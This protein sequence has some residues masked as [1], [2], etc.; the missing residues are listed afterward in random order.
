MV[1][2]DSVFISYRRSDARA[3]A[4]GLAHELSSRLGADH[5]FLDTESIEGGQD[6]P[7]RIQEAL[8]RAR[9]VLVVIGSNWLRAADEWGVRRIDNEEDFVRREVIYALET[10]GVTTIPILLDGGKMPPK[11]K[12]P[13]VIS[14]L[15]E[16]QLMPLDHTQFQGHVNQ[17]AEHIRKLGVEAIGISSSPNTSARFDPEPRDLA[18]YR[19]ALE[20][21]HSAMELVGFQTR[22]RVPIDIEELHVPLRAL[23]D[24]RAHGEAVFS[25]AEDAEKSLQKAEGA[26][27]IQ[28]S[29]AFREA[30]RLRRRGLVILGDPG[31]GK[32][33]QLKCLL[34]WLL[35]RG[36]SDLG[37]GNG[38]P[39]VPV[40]LRL[41][42]LRDI[43]ADLEVFIEQQ[44]A[45]V[46][47]DLTP[48]FGKALL[49]RGR[50]LLLFDGLDEVADPTS[51]AVVARWIEKVSRQRPTSMPVVT[52]RFAGYGGDARL[53]EMFLELH[54]RPLTSEQAE[55]FIS[56]WYDVVEAGLAA[57]PAKSSNQAHQ[58]ATALIER[59]RE[60]DF[61]TAR[62]AQMTR[63][64]LLLANLCLVHRDSG[65]L[66][67]GRARLYTE[68]VDVLLERWREGKDL[69][70][71]VPSEVGRRALQPAAL[72]LHGQKG[73]DELRRTRATA[74][75]LAP[76]IES[77]LKSARWQGGNAADFLRAV[78]DES[79]LLTGWG[80]EHFG[81][82]HLGFQEYL[83]ASEVRRR[84]AE[85]DA[86]P[87]KDLAAQYGVSWW[88]EVILL[89]LS[90]SNPSMF[91]RFMREVVKQRSFGETFEPMGLI[92][93]DAVEVSDAP[94]I[95]LLEEVPEN[96]E[97][98]WQRQLNALRALEAIGART[99]IDSLRER[100]SQHPLAAI[101]AR[102][103]PPKEQPLGSAAAKLVHEVTGIE[104]V[105]IPG[106]TFFMGSNGKHD[107]DESP[108]HRV[109][110]SG[111][112]IS[113]YP[114]T[115]EQYARFLQANL[116]VKE[117]RY[118]ADR[119]FNQSR[120]PVVGI[121]WEEANDY[122]EW[123]GLR[124][125]TEAEWEYACRAGTDTEYFSG[126]S[127]F[128]LGTVGWYE[129]NS[130]QRLHDV[131]ELMPN[132]FGLCDMHGNI[133]TRPPTAPRCPERA[134]AR[135]A[136]QA[137]ARDRWARAG[138]G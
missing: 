104:L 115:N 7:E 31:S 47:P 78:R 37:L 50:L 62:L 12:L 67:H 74:E 84:A 21:T 97:E 123:A 137:C 89:L 116:K 29:E 71:T 111:L 96:D 119:R 135:T 87:L 82:M 81:F 18:R 133:V 49:R 121:R 59:L 17:V 9:V 10:S 122:A 6:F 61:R 106:G 3:D 28:F 27:E 80:P 75:E 105:Y 69:A 86:D 124:L 136:R 46:H 1:V 103:E 132:A 41:R 5:V 88:Q 56:N 83:A 45:A 43:S 110:I 73:Q 99:S 118:W 36:D 42:E 57:N 93:E 53:N 109:T 128:D 130:G 39:L 30:D 66:P 54:L 52:C 20:A 23:V 68:C 4:R 60:P 77:A 114:V 72:W 138:G 51:R 22:V 131:G 95:E 76:V 79:G 107:R 34:L 24:L 108:R 125:V 129:R 8:D 64:P 127:E 102:L 101:R 85:E 70:V 11:D 112:Y 14:K 38:E 90:M 40:F 25:N 100:L 48:G 26:H 55:Q 63:N 98:L 44:L 92:L 113:Q 91:E 33:T 58:R 35:R 94:F 15:A 120:Q 32:T 126:N 16:R 19:E 65:K 13:A 117:P 134:V 2:R